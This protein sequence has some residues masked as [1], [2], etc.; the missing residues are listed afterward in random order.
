MQPATPQGP[1]VLPRIALLVGGTVLGLL[2]VEAALHA[3]GFVPELSWEWQLESRDRVPDESA[4][5]INPRFL[6]DSHYETGDAERV[7]VALGDSFT[8]GYPVG[9][10]AAWPAL[11]EAQRR[12]EGEN[13][14]VLSFGLGNSGPE[15]HL[16]ILEDHILARVQPDDILWTFY[17]NDLGDDRTMQ[18]F[19]DNAGELAPLTGDDHW[20]H[21]RMVAWRGV[22]RWLRKN[23]ALLRYWIASYEDRSAQNTEPDIEADDERFRRV[24]ARARSTAERA[25]ARLHLL[26]IRPELT[27]LAESDPEAWQHHWLM[28]DHRRLRRLLAEQPGFVEIDVAAP[29]LG[30]AIRWQDLFVETARDGAAIGDHHFNEE[31]Q[32]RFARAVDEILGAPSRPK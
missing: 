3:T 1:G 9:W 26:L 15:Q 5:L 8:E 14:R 29:G 32:R 23:S 10:N 27:Y 24:L 7:M 13:T 28:R 18:R 4:I 17:A 19:A 2:L 6:R 21:Q 22:P 25:G 16:R 30:D 31:G 20:I 11:L 12:D